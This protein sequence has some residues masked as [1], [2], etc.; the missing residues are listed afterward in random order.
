MDF[1]YGRSIKNQLSFGKKITGTHKGGRM[2]DSLH[3]F[4]HHIDMINLKSSQQTKPLRNTCVVVTC[5]LQ[6]DSASEKCATR[7]NVNKN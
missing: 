3:K 1:D 2:R 5:S 7:E 4:S 6:V